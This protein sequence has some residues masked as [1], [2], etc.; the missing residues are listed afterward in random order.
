MVLEFSWT[1]EQDKDQQTTK[2]N[3]WIMLTGNFHMDSI[4]GH[5]HQNDSSLPIKKQFMI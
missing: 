3:K 4:Q 5:S 2:T 1:G